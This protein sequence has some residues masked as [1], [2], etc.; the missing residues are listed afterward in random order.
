MGKQFILYS[1]KAYSEPWKASK[2]KL[3]VKIVNHFQS[4]TISAKSSI[5]SW[6][7]DKVSKL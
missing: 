6:M 4:L 1:A 5:L 2:M 7:F 3:L